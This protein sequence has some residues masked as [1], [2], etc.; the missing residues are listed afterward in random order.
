MARLTKINRAGKLI[1]QMTKLIQELAASGVADTDSEDDT[2][3]L[4]KLKA[5]IVKAREIQDD[6]H[7]ELLIR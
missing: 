4:N 2:F 7:F 6:E 3:E 5:F 1:Q